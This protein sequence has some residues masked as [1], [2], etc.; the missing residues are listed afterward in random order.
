MPEL[1]KVLNNKGFSHMKSGYVNQDTIENF[2]G[3]IRSYGLRYNTPT[4]FQTEGLLKALIVSNLTSKHFIGANCL[5]DKATPLASL[6]TFTAATN[7][8]TESSGAR[9]QEFDEHSH[10]EEVLKEKWSSLRVASR[11]Q[12]AGRFAKMVLS[13]IKGI[14][15]CNNCEKVFFCDDARN[16]ENVSL[17]QKNNFEAINVA[18]AIYIEQEFTRVINLVNRHLRLMCWKRHLRK[19]LTQFLLGRMDFEWVTC[20]QHCTL[21]AERFNQ[22]IVVNC[23]LKWCTYINRILTGQTFVTKG[24]SMEI[25]AHKKYLTTKKQ[26]TGIEKQ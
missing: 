18:A 10:S 1:W 16:N 3:C 17:L 6:G 21:I 5:D 20:P 7:T 15:D 4:C 25:R 12:S 14:K 8:N 9:S 23:I 19:V 13:E 2:F 11:V 26:K 24:S 22:C